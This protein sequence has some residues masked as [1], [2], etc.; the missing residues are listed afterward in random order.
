MSGAP[1]D[2]GPRRRRWLRVVLTFVI[3]ITAVLIPLALLAGGVLALWSFR[4]AALEWSIVRLADALDLGP[5]EVTVE[6]IDTTS[7]RVSGLRMGPKGRTRIASI[8]IRHTIEGLLAGRVD[9]VRVEGLRLSG[10]LDETGLV[11][12]DLE[13]AFAGDGDGGGAT[14]PVL[15]A[16]HLEV[17]DARIDLDTTFG[18]IAT[19]VDLELEPRADAALGTNARL[20]LTLPEGTLAVTAQGVVTEDDRESLVADLRLT[21]EAAGAV[22]GTAIGKLRAT[23]GLDG[24]ISGQL[25]LADAHLAHARAEV[26]GLKGIVDFARSADRVQ[27]IGA[28]LTF[29]KLDTGEL[30]LRPGRVEVAL[31][32]A[33]LT[34][35]ADL[36]ATEGEIDL[37]MSGTLGVPA[38]TLAFAARGAVD[39]SAL[40]RFAPTPGLEGAIAYDLAG[41]ARDP[42]ALRRLRDAPLATW[43]RHIGLEGIVELDVRGL[44]WPGM[45]A[46]AGIVGRFAVAARDE[47][48]LIDAVEE[49][50]L[51]IENLELDPAAYLPPPLATAFTGPVVIDLEQ[52]LALLIAPRLDGYDVAVS[53]GLGFPETPFDLRVQADA[54]VAL[55]PNLQVAAVELPFLL[56][57]ASGLRGPA[58]LEEAEIVATD[59]TWKEN[60]ASGQLAAV[61]RSAGASI[62]G[63]EASASTIE[64]DTGF[65]MDADDLT[66]RPGA[67]TRATLSGVKLPGSLTLAGPLTISLD[68]G[69]DN[70]VRVPLGGDPFAYEL[71]LAPIRVAAKLAA[72]TPVD[73]TA[74]LEGLRLSGGGDAHTLAFEATAELPVY[75]LRLAGIQ[76]RLAVADRKPQG[77]LRISEIAHGHFPPLV[78]PVRALASL[79]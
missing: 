7:V 44:D 53:G 41:T 39:A 46:G 1:P 66:V 13:Q 31:D 32:G 50:R 10:R 24:S 9:L 69:A 40:R 67:A 30:A 4:L 11:I 76:G 58:G 3:P 26:A 19:A 51:R 65:E 35:H 49:T 16:E 23:A 63:V 59:T 62:S 72:E 61:L 21:A 56:L 33:E 12:A 38:P 2:T 75:A 77:E 47:E 79:R 18:P 6:R 54:R 45:V 71:A 27:R 28:E 15:P 70:V 74:E 78:V 14:M 5:A 55:E 8:D 43:L 60:R 48:V 34:A 57:A 42:A 25:E 64:I 68:A 22:V 36:T 20:R 73:M 29:E 37:D 52:A 17:V